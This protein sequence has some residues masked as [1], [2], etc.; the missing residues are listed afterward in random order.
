LWRATT[1]QAC[2]TDAALKLARDEFNATHRPKLR[3]RLVHF[4]D[5]EPIRIHYTVVNIGETRAILKRHEITLSVQPGPVQPGD[6]VD[7][8]IQKELSLECPQ[9]KGGESRPFSKNIDD[10]FNVAWGI[11]DDGSI[12]KIQG[13]I[14]YE[15]GAGTTRRT[16][17]LRTYDVKLGHFRASG[18]IEEE[19]ED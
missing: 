3:V 7:N 14:E 9:L 13:I 11:F 15:D 2:I 6:N 17:F 16:G 12:L 19:Y 5:D 8:P 4:T 18:D 10:Q 1:Q